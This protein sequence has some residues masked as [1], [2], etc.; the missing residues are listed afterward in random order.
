MSDF[1]TATIEPDTERLMTTA[2]VARWLNVKEGTLRYWRHTHRG[3]R[4]LTLAGGVRYRPSD[5]EEW[6]ESGA[7]RG[8][9]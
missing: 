1:R 4:S 9:R 5:I 8:S 3:P 7:K 6:L 2:E